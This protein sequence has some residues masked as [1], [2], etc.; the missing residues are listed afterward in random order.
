MSSENWTIDSIAHALPHPE[1]R[2]AFMQET[3]FTDVTK[4][5]GILAKWVD[6][7]E[8]FEAERPRVEA[9]R[10]YYREHGQLPA[11]YE[12]ESADGAALYQQ[13]KGQQ[14]QGAA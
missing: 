5:P 13:W 9:V 8:R 1:L 4:L 12:T 10:D 7:I 3:S 14:Q 11:E 2:A 6:F